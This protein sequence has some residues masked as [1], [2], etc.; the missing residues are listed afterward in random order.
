LL[1][2]GGAPTGTQTQPM[3]GLPAPGAGGKAGAAAPAAETAK[4][5][6]TQ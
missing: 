1:K 6:W 3:V 2:G 5:F 4:Q